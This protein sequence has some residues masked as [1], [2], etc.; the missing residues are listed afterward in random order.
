MTVGAG[1]TATVGDTLKVYGGGEVDLNGGTIDTGRLGTVEGLWTWG[2]GALN[3]TDPTYEFVVGVGG[4]FGDTLSLP[5]AVTMTVAGQTTVDAG[6]SLTSAD[7][8]GSGKV[9]NHGTIT[10]TG[11]VVLGDT[12]VLQAYS[13]AGDLVVGSNDLTLK[14]KGFVQI[15][16]TIDLTGGTLSVPNG[17]AFD[18]AGYFTGHGTIDG[19]IAAAV[20]STI[21]ATGNLTLGDPNAYDGVYSDGVIDVGNNALTLL[22]ADRAV[23]GSLTLI[24]NADPNDDAIHATN[25]LLIDFGKTLQGY[26]RVTGQTMMNGMTHCE[27]S[28]IEF[29]SNV[30][31]VGDFTGPV[32]YSGGYTP[33][34]SPAAIDL[35][36]V[37]FTA[38]NTLVLEIGGM[39]PGAD[40][41][42]LNASGAVT[43]GGVL[44]LRL[45]G[46]FT[47]TIGQ[48]FDL[49]TT[50]GRTGHFDSVLGVNHGPYS[51]AAI[52]AGDDLVLEI[53]NS[54]DST[55]DGVIDVGDLAVVGFNWG[56]SATWQTGDLNGDGLVDV[57]DLAVV[58]FNWGAGT[59][60]PA[61]D[62][63]TIPLPGATPVGLAG[64]MALTARRTTRRP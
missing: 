48:S 16:G 17:I 57:G 5:A 49:I 13:G 59:G 61:L 40:H 43:Y 8:T 26:G 33:G 24:G 41:D 2:S 14:S 1:G 20:D 30:N 45:I 54:G 64:L 56:Q 42:Q 63:T 21:E 22:D 47:P 51:L 19:R 23:L 62:G 10:S 39:A 52:Y 18:V 29:M 46:G 36:D 58:G 37:T 28:G 53:L 50:A 55:R 11:S 4:P 60:G 27:G 6:A 3:I 34:F 31:G 15:G 7:Y 25:G 44:D 9:V 12:S 35:D 32:T 38:T